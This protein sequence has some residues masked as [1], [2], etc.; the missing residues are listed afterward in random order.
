MTIRQARLE[1]APAI[2]LVHVES[3]RSSYTGIMPGDYIAR[4]TV[5]R[6]QQ[7]WQSI[8]NNPDAKTRLFV[9]VDDVSGQIVGFV[10]CGPQRDNN[11]HDFDGELY[12]IY[13]LD[14]AQGKGYGRGLAKAAGRCLKDDGYHAMLLWVLDENPKARS[15]YEAM[16]GELLE[17]DQMYDMNG[18]TLREIAY[19]WRDLNALANHQPKPR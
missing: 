12:A 14:S 9:A 17:I 6:R 11:I 4:Q 18:Q 7:M 10:A 8:L 2:A 5:E 16:G 13:L 15:F 19:G 3:W 1:D